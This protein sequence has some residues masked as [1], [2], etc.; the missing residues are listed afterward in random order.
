MNPRQAIKR[1]RETIGRGW[2]RLTGRLDLWVNNGLQA[3]NRGKI[4]TT[5]PIGQPEPRFMWMLGGTEKHCTDCAALD[6]QVKTSSE[7]ASA[8]IQPQSPDLECGGWRCDCR[9]EEV[10]NE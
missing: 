2:D 5:P 1:V 10:S 3:W 9:L 8:G 7:W 6:G 4:E